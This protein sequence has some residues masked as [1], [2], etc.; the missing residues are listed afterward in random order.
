[1]YKSHALGSRESV[2]GAHSGWCRGNIHQL[3]QGHPC[4]FLVA[5]GAHCHEGWCVREVPGRVLWCSSS[6][7][8]SLRLPGRKWLTTPQFFLPQI[9]STPYFLQSLS[10]WSDVA[11][12]AALWSSMGMTRWQPSKESGESGGSAMLLGAAAR[13]LAR[14]GDPGEPV[15]LILAR[16][17]TKLGSLSKLVPSLQNE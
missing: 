1:M 17:C 5:L 14:L 15:V 11:K 6:S 13:D 7:S 4:G 8:L 2:L 10:G 16:G 9:C 3:G 12:A